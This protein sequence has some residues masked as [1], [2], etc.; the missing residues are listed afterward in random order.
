M[1]FK[2]P[3]GYVL[4]RNEP[5]TLNDKGFAYAPGD[6][7]MPDGQ[8]DVAWFDEEEP[9]VFNDGSHLPAHPARSTVDAAAEGWNPKVTLKPIVGGYVPVSYQLRGD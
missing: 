8:I 4:I 3:K 5:Q 6:R 7:L 2:A 1:S 9:F